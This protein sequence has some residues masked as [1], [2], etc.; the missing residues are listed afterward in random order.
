MPYRFRKYIK[1]KRASVW[2]FVKL[3]IPECCYTVP[4]TLLGMMAL[5][6]GIVALASHFFWIHGVWRGTMR[7]NMATWILWSVFDMA[8]FITSIAAGAPAPFMAAGFALGAIL[9]T[10]TLLF[11]GTWQWGRL[12]TVCTILAACCFFVWYASGPLVALVSFLA[13]KYAAG[14]LP[15]LIEAYRNPEPRQ[16]PVWW[17]GSFG[18]ATNIFATGS[19]TLAQSLFPTTALVFSFTI[20]LLH[21]GRLRGRM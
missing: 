16:S 12:E 11:K 13:A 14:G 10:L 20:G 7:L 9:L 2:N 15:T 4:M 1:E 5:L 6:G 21:T 18:A 17:M 8:A 3:G 19:W